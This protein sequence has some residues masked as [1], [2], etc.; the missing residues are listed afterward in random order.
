MSEGELTYFSFIHAMSSSFV[1]VETDK[2]TRKVDMTQLKAT[3][4]N[5]LSP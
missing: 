3:K 4:S 1:V 2:D 5:I